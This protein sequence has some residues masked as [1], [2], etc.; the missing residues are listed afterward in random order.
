MTQDV[1]WAHFDTGYGTR[2]E[3]DGKMIRSCCK[4]S[5]GGRNTI[6]CEQYAS[7]E[8]SRRKSEA[9]RLREDAEQGPK[10]V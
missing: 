4:R 2:S 9:E 8:R 3:E 5:Y 10:F 1:L 7:H 6:G